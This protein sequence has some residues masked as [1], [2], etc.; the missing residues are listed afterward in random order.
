MQERELCWQSASD[1]AERIGRGEISPV[2][3]VD[4][5]LAR[6][7]RVN[8]H[9]NAFLTVL[10]EPARAAAREAERELAK[11]GPRGPLH[12][13]PVA[14]KDIVYTRGVRTTMGSSIFADFVPDEDATVVE[15]FRAAGAILI[16]KAHTH[17][18]AFG[19][20][21][22]NPHYGP[23]R[24]PWNLDCI[25]GG[26]SG[27]SAAGVAAALCPIAIGSDTGGSIRLPG[28]LCGVVG[29]KPTYGRVSRFGVF[30][31]AWTLDH[32]GPLTRSARDAALALRFIAGYDPRDP[33]TSRLPV[34]DYTATLT[35]D[36]R[37]IRVGV[38]REHQAEPLDGEV[39]RLVTR[40]IQ[41]IRDLGAMVD[42]VSIPSAAYAR[43]VA[44]TL[45]AVE[46][47][48]VHEPLLREHA[49]DY[50]GDVRQRFPF[51][52][53]VS[54]LTFVRAQQARTRIAADVRTALERFDVLLGP[55]V[56][57][58]APP[59]GQETAVIEGREHAVVPMLSTLTRLHNLT[60]LP[61]VTVPC[62]YTAAGL[63]VGLEVAGRP[64]EEAV[65]LR[66][67]DAYEC[68]TAEQR[69]RPPVDD[70]T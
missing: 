68:A 64:F 59:I 67:A 24:N 39:R 20:T 3:L 14:L 44:T 65:V 19:A 12:G 37:G 54:A 18:F 16:A 4:A 21:S 47:L 35:G 5:Y 50:G 41:E 28:A 52:L 10:A 36:V 8:S 42:E 40:A 58:P 22:N 48:A 9:L 2:E 63:P 27:G 25:P 15:R 69:R 66:V 32:I 57:V 34:P 55:T 62:G 46:S 7:E 17:E 31:G 70:L 6:I 53:G 30:P 56:P 1:L 13:V 38:L 26:S 61:A 29:L 49:E 51:P 43:P 45:T 33:T 60:G 23:C 11:G